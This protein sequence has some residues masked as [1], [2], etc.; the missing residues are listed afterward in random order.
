MNSKAHFYEYYDLVYD[1]LYDGLL[2]AVLN[3]FICHVDILF[4]SINVFIYFLSLS[5]STF[6]WNQ[7]HEKFSPIFVFSLSVSSQS[8][9]LE[10]RCGSIVS[11][12]NLFRLYKHRTA[13]FGIK[14]V[15][16]RKICLQFPIEYCCGINLMAHKFSTQL[17][18]ANHTIRSKQRSA[19]F[20]WWSSICASSIQKPT[21]KTNEDARIAKK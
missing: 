6:D 4:V 7:N 11:I 2:W 15:G 8:A 13:T 3:G 10:S 18:G 14:S 9:S 5:Y 16:G 21:R 19:N 12:W 1:F 17:I 20:F